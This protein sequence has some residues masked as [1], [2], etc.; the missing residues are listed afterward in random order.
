[1][2]KNKFED[3]AAKYGLDDNSFSNQSYFFDYDNDGDLDMYLVNHRTD[4][5]NTTRMSA[6]V[7]RAIVPAFSDQ[8]YRNDGNN[9]T[10]VTAQAGITEH[11][12]AKA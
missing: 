5:A 4:W 2:G 6:E 7:Q 9:F 8:M 1:M 10:N 12:F 3:Q 11:L